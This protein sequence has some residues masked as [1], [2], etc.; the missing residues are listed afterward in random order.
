MVCREAVMECDRKKERLLREKIRELSLE[1]E[2]L[3]KQSSTASAGIHAVR[4]RVKVKEIVL[5]DLQKRSQV[6][7]GNLRHC[8]K[9]YEVMKKAR[10]RYAN[11]V[12]NTFQALSEMA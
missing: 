12:Q 9:Q 5:M 4:Q 6:V 10:N 7:V 8:R 11:L 3:L 2:Q 1:R